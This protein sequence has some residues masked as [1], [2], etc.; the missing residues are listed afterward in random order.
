MKTLAPAWSLA[1]IH[2]Q[3]ECDRAGH[4]QVNARQAKALAQRFGISTSVFI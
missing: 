1:A 4:R 2:T 3:A